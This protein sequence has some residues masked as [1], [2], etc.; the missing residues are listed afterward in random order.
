MFAFWTLIAGIAFYGLLASVDF[1]IA[2][3]LPKPKPPERRCNVCNYELTQN[4]SGRC[5]ECRKACEM[6]PTCREQRPQ[7]R[8]ARVLQRRRQKR[9][10]AMVKT[11]PDKSSS[12]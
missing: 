11:V 6:D 9:V 5:P 10:T 8:E 12:A 2:R 1:E 3:L 4:V 7:I